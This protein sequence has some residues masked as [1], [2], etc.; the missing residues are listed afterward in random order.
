[1]V[2]DSEPCELQLK[3]EKEIAQYIEEE[4]DRKMHCEIE[5]LIAENMDQVY[6]DMDSRIC[7]AKNEM[8][9]EMYR[10]KNE[11]EEEFN[12]KPKRSFWKWWK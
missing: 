7:E 12:L 8:A 1:M 4:H 5:P 11:L 10:M 9:Y 6:L 2:M 3:I